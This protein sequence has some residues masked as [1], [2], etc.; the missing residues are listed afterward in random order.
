MKMPDDE[1]TVGVKQH[2]AQW[3][4]ADALID[5]DWESNILKAAEVSY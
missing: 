4:N 2:S 1:N 3:L 5:Y